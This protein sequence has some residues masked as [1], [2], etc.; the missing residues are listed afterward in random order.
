[1]QAKKTMKQKI[2]MQFD[3]PFPFYSEE[4]DNEQ[5]CTADTESTSNFS[6]DTTT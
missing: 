2:P 6:E 5:A 3:L 4:R 1:M